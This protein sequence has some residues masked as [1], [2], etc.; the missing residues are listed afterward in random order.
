L[1]GACCVP[2]GCL[3]VPEVSCEANGGIYQ[4]DG[5]VCDVD[6]CPGSTD[7]ACCQSDGGCLDI[8]QV[9]CESDGGLYQGDGTVC[10]VG[11]CDVVCGDADID[12]SVKAGDA[13]IALK[14][15]VGSAGCVVA[16]CDYDGS[17]KVTASD[18]L[19]ILK[20]AVGQPITPNCP[21]A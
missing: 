6:V 11:V 5:S 21:D 7:G 17:G 2:E 20:T 14:T 10:D 1:D 3:D 12:G 18:A 15:A 19:S 9:S 4:G 16:R 13:L 8:T